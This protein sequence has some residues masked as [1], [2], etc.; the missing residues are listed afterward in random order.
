MSKSS[1]RWADHLARLIIRD[2]GSDEALVADLLEPLCAAA[3]LG[4]AM[5]RSVRKATRRRESIM[6]RA[7]RP[8]QPPA[9]VT[10]LD[11]RRWRTVLQP[12]PAPARING[13][14][15]HDLSFSPDQGKAEA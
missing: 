7:A 8:P 9:G 14:S 4:R 6:R 11:T 3:D 2:C 1:R 12:V 10:E 15:V 13:S 5:E